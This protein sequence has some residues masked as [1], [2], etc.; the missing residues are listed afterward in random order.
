MP[1]TVTKQERETNQSLVRK[2]SRAVQRGGVLL[3]ARKRRFHARPSSES[4]KHQKALR[5]EELRARYEK[6]RKLGKIR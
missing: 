3:E 5:R 4:K 6:L 2:F 1:V